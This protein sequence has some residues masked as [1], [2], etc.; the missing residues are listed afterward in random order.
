MSKVE[1]MIIFVLLVV[2]A[3]IS[4]HA[5]YSRVEESKCVL[6]PSAEQQIEFIE[7]SKYY[8]KQW[9]MAS[10]K[11]EDYCNDDWQEFMNCVDYP[12]CGLP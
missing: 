5:T 3:S 12:E 10:G 6:S 1:R 2:F 7:A 11:S 8:S 4:I 9:C